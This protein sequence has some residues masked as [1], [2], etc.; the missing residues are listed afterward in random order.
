ME[1]IEKINWGHSSGSVGLDIA[2]R[3]GIKQVIFM[4]HDPA[5]TDEKVF[6]AET[7]VRRYH[8]T[9][10]KSAMRMGMVVNSVDWK[11]AVEGMEIT[12]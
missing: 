9:Q 3:E 1:S 4:H 5:S 11:F 7:E 12:L 8:Q 10:I 2:M 6:A